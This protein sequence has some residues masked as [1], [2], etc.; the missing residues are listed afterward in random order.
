MAWWPIPFMAADCFVAAYASLHM[1]NG[2]DQ[3]QMDLRA[4]ATNYS[5]ILGLGLFVVAAGFY[6]MLLRFQQLSVLYPI[7]ALTYVVSAF[8]AKKYI[9]EEIGP[10]KVAGIVSIII[11]VSIVG[12]AG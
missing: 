1:K 8:L 9:G 5:L 2:S 3:L 10:W 7:G 12:L 11:G 6:F 4:I